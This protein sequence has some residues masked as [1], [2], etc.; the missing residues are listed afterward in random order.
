MYASNIVYD[1]DN[2]SAYADVCKLSHN[3]QFSMIISK[4]VLSMPKGKL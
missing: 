3:K 4:D 2:D 1:V